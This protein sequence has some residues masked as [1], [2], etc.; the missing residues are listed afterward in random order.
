M[1]TPKDEKGAEPATTIAEIV[2]D[3]IEGYR[4]G[5]AGG[6]MG[7]V[8]AAFDCGWTHGA[9]ERGATPPGE[10]DRVREALAELVAANTQHGP[11]VGKALAKARAALAS[12]KGTETP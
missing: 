2:G 3:A 6:A 11:S 5:L 12:L 9:Q 1:T 8:S 4:V 7:F 10:L